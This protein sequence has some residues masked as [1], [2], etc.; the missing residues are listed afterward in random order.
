M[1]DLCIGCPDFEKF[2]MNLKMIKNKHFNKKINLKG[3][4]YKTYIALLL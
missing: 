3:A 1:F 4:M 2:N